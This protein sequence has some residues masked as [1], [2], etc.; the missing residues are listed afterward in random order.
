[1]KKS[2][3]GFTLIEVLVSLALLGGSLFIGLELFRQST[4]QIKNQEIEMSF[5]TI[6]KTVR[7]KVQYPGSCQTS[8][9]FPSGFNLAQAA[10][11]SGIPIRIS[12][13]EDQ[14]KAIQDDLKNFQGLDIRSIRLARLLPSDLASN[15]NS[16]TGIIQISA[17]KNQNLIG[18]KDLK[19]RIVAAV[20]IEVDGAGNYVGCYT[21]KPIATSCQELGG[22]F[23]ADSEPNCQFQVTLGSC[24]NANEYLVGFENGQPICQNIDGACN[25]GQYLSGISSSGIIC[26]DI[27]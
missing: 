22:T 3:N 15:P 12:L 18:G 21:E 25:D 23:K 10:T 8:L 11:N 4:E 5:S 26:S 14:G 9:S 13:E 16:Y 19:D 2:N 27:N 6:A 24:T 20:T 17:E 1:M 7:Q